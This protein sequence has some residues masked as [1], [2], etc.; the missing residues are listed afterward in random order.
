MIPLNFLVTM[1]SYRKPQSVG[2]LTADP[3]VRKDYHHLESDRALPHPLAAQKRSEVEDKYV[4]HLQNPEDYSQQRGQNIGERT[5]R[6]LHN[7][8]THFVFG[9]GYD[10]KTSETVIHA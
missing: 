5:N 6:D 3:P 2:S 1:L 9:S 4:V 8:G 7:K 10:P